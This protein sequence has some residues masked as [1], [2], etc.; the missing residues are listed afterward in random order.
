MYRDTV[1]IDGLISVT[2]CMYVNVLLPIIALLSSFLCSSVFCHIIRFKDGLIFILGTFLLLM[3]FIHLFHTQLLKFCL[4]PFLSSV[5]P[6]CSL[7]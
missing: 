4:V 7:V 5:I 6:T 3:L 1:I 2:Q